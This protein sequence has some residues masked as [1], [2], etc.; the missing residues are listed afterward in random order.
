MPIKVSVVPGI[1]LSVLWRGIV[2]SW[3]DGE[4]CF[5]PVG[6]E[7]R[8]RGPEE[9]AE[10]EINSV[11]SALTMKR[12]DCSSSDEGGMVPISV[13]LASSF[14]NTNDFGCCAHATC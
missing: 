11:G 2:R 6:L 9:R 4:V 5:A 13:Q 3:E 8:F 7:A 10:E 12:V 1:S 14:S